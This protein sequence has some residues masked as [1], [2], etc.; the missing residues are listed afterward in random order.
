MLSVTGERQGRS[1]RRTQ[2]Q[3]DESTYQL[4]RRRA[5]ERGMSM[6]ALLREALMQH[7]AQESPQPRFK[8]FT[9][10]GSGNSD[11]GNLQPVS[12]R[13]DEALTEALQ[14]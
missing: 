4:L 8:D 2:I 3:L 1:M 12:E 14:P 13:H 6:A 5:F 7:L 9:F 10:V 11:D